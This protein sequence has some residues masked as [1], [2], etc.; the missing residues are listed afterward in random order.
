M[1]YGDWIC[2]KCGNQYGKAKPGIATWHYG[3][4]DWCG[5]RKTPV[6]EPRDYGYPDMPEG[7]K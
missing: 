2:E 1:T 7:E 3:V 6:T 5:T 4:C